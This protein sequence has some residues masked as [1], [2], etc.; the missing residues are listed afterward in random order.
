MTHMP[1]SASTLGCPAWDLPT[2][3]H[4]LPGY[5]FGAVEL[6]GLRDD[7]DVS[8]IPEFTTHLTETRRM[9]ADAGL[10][11]SCIAS[12]IRV[13]VPE[14]QKD[15]L[16]E[17]RRMIAV[18]RG[19]NVPNIRV[20]GGGDLK[21]LSSEGL[22]DIGAVTIEKI[23]ALD[24]ASEVRWCIETHDI[25]TASKSV[26]LF[27]D[28]IDAENVGVL[29]DVGHTTRMGPETPFD[30]WSLLGSRT[31]NTHFRDAVHDPAHPNAMADGWRY[32]PLGLGQLPLEEAMAVLKQK[33]YRGYLTLEHEKRWHP[34]LEEPENIFPK[35]AAWFAQQLAPS[36]SRT[37]L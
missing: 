24:G 7:L 26:K 5:G 31:F 37:S 18:A 22:I 21:Q 12:S 17:A 16:E 23:L 29:W 6:R 10:A 14:T 4:R 34:D 20:F 27:L 11:V 33:S 25:W 13:C 15:N 30:S 9:F 36:E 3:I 2:I 35:A 19:L 28:R 8:L 1:I 32:V